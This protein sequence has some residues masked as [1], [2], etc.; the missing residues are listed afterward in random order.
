MRHGDFAIIALA[1]AVS[2]ARSVLAVGG[3]ADRPHVLRWPR[4]SDRDID[5]ALHRLSDEIEA[6]DDQHASATYRRY[7]V[8]TLGARLLAG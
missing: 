2:D 3:V 6:R 1:A 7:L 8:R 5:E 4:L